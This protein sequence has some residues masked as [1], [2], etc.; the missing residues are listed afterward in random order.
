[1][2]HGLSNYSFNVREHGNHDKYGMCGVDLYL[3]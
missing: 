2:L 1:M 3:K